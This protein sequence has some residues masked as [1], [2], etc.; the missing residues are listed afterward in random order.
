MARIVEEKIHI[1]EEKF[2]EELKEKF[3]NETD[4]LIGEN[5]QKCDELNTMGLEVQH[6]EA[7]NIEFENEIFNL[8][9]EN[10]NLGQELQFSIENGR[11]LEKVLN[12]LKASFS[13]IFPEDTG[14]DTIR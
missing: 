13:F 2:R 4:K 7:D 11:K 8:R 10:V 3:E 14:K 5:I 12:D 9:C 6:L 1:L